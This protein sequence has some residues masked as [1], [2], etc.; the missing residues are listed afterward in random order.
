MNYGIKKLG[1]SVTGSFI[2]TQPFFTTIASVLIF[3]EQINFSKILAAVM[4]IAGVFLTNFKK[5]A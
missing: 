4:I 1:A 5:S 3:E 2:Y